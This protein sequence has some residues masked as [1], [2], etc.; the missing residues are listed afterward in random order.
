MNS[1]IPVTR[2]ALPRIS[3]RLTFFYAE[4]C[5]IHRDQNALTV[6]DNR[7]VIHV[8]A[9]SLAC[10]MMGPGTTVSHAAVTLLTECGV[11]AVWVGERGVRFYA[12]GRSL[13]NSTALLL[14][15]A[16]RVSIRSERLAVARAMYEMRFHEPVDGLTMQQLRGREGARMRELYRSQADRTGVPWKRR[17]YSQDNFDDSDPI[18]QALSASNAALYGIVH[19]AI[20]ALGCAPG[21]GF[22][23]TGHERAFV[24]DIADLY[25]A[26]TTIPLSFDI[27]SEHSDQITVIARR[28]VRDRIFE[29]KILE[30][31]VRDIR[32]LLGKDESSEDDIEVKLVS[33]W[34]YQSGAIAAGKNYELSG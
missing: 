15:Q 25:K 12:S 34:D 27:A 7:G 6:R 30:R 17:S 28:A 23:H 20:V 32:R 2:L 13:A 9:A 5:V 29:Q 19:S 8:P 18:N 3:D 16:R 31:S 21:L 1:R 11:G 10:V 24:Y 14:E 26:E 33:L 4:Q 22:V